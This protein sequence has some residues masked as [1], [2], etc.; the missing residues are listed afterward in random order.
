MKK[1]FILLFLAIAF[2]SCKKQQEQP[3]IHENQ[4]VKH[5]LGS[6]L[7]GRT[8]TS[9]IIGAQG[10][11]LAS[12]DGSLSLTIPAGALSE[13]TS[14]SIQAVENTLP[15]SR[16]TS[17]QLLPEGLIFKKPV[18]IH[19]SYS[20]LDLEG[21]TR[22][23]LR[24]AYQDKEGYYHMPQD[25]SLDPFSKTLKVQSI[26][27]SNWTVFECYRLVGPNS[28]IPGGTADLK[29]KTYVPI[30]PL[31]KGEDMLLGDYIESE[32]NDPILSSAV[33]KLVGE[34]IINPY[35]RGCSYVAPPD[36]PNQNPI[37]ISVELTG[38]FFGSGTSKHQKLILLKPIAIEGS[39]YF[40]VNLDGV[41]TRVTMGAFFTTGEGLY[42]SGIMKDYQFNIKVSAKRVGNF[43]FK[44]PTALNGADISLVSQVD[45][46]D[47]MSSFRTA[48]N[49][50][51]P[52]FVF[53]PGKVEISKYP[54]Q[55]G[56]FLQGI[57]SGALLYTG[58]NYCA[59]PKIVKLN[60][61]FKLLPK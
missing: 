42:I 41:S 43:P 31:S 15:G 48:C 17:F 30:G 18:A 9:K 56:E 26:H 22:E 44:L 32:D 59:A 33:W 53:S 34:G 4:P 36:V 47:Y 8:L 40:T 38:N 2:W 28:V 13:N 58:G 52:N 27:F 12:D 54:A 39:E 10:G 23:L 49:E 29:L 61:S 16:A 21:S 11:S 57:V 46:L 25:F 7:P 6:P 60:A 24:P 20:A 55:P 19:F 5:R 45:M 51:E 35:D 37:T 14:I 50:N 3:T 1:H